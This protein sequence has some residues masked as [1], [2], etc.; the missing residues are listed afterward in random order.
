MQ[1]IKTGFF[2]LLSVDVGLYLRYG[3]ANEALEQVAWLI[4][5]ATFLYDSLDLDLAYASRFEQ[6]GIHAAQTVGYGLA[7]YTCWGYWTAG[8]MS[9]F[10]NSA[11]WLAICALLAYDVYAPGEYGG[12]EWRARN[13]AKVLLY[14]VVVGLVGLWGWQ[15]V[16]EGDADSL[17][18]A[19]DAALWIGCFAIVELRVFDF[20]MKE[21]AGLAQHPTGS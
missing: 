10:V 7:V 1:F 16:T 17:V 15:G 3:T 9:S 4:L 18:S 21:E 14:T 6:F 19:Y 8:D 12:L 20:E 11:A 13:V 2:L 5:L